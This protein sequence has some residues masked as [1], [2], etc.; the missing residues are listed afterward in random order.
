M[1]GFFTGGTFDL[2]RFTDEVKSVAEQAM[3]EAANDV[4]DDSDR[5]VPVLTGRLKRS[6]TVVIRDGKAVFGYKD[7]KARAAHE[8]MRV[9]Y[10]NGK[11][12]KFLELAAV[13]FRPSYLQILQ[14]HIAKVLGG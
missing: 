7:P 3:L 11:T 4:M 5:R 13:N 10:R 2:S 8:N 12:A 1:S 14:R 6:R 9:H